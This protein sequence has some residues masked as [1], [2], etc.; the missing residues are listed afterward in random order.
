VTLLLATEPALDAEIGQVVGKY[1]LAQVIGKGGFGAVYRARHL[2]TGQQVALKILARTHDEIATKRFF[3]EA[4]VS[5]M[6][7]HPNTVRVFD[8]GQ[9][10]AGR[11]YLAMEL[12][13]GRSLR[14]AMRDRQHKE[15][16]FSEREAAEIGVAI[17]KSLAEAHRAGLV[18]RDIKPDNIFL[19]QIEDEDPVVKLL[20]FGI[21]KLTDGNESITSNSAIPGTPTFMSPEHAM[22]GHLD[23]RADLYSVGILLFLMVAGRVPFRAENAIQTLYM[24]V[25]IPVPDLN[26]VARTPLTPGFVAI[27]NKALQKDPAQRFSSAREMRLA[28]EQCLG[29]GWSQHSTS[30]GVVIP[31]LNLRY[32][33]VVDASGEA[34]APAGGF[35]PPITGRDALSEAIAPAGGFIPPI[36]GRDA[37]SEAIAPAGGFIPPITGRDPSAVPLSRQS[38]AQLGRPPGPEG[39]RPLPEGLGPPEVLEQNTTVLLPD[40]EPPPSSAPRR[41]WGR[42]RWLI[43]IG[44]LAAALSWAV[45]RRGEGPSAASPED[46]RAIVIAPA[47]RPSPSAAPTPAS[48]AMAPPPAPVALATSTAA[49]VPARPMA[50]RRGPRGHERRSSS[51]APR[52]P[53]VDEDVLNTRLR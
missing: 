15:E 36:T 43:A 14:Q 3:Q 41:S 45:V 21:A 20:D 2:A 10:E 4:Q 18:H 29:E 30:N 6:L 9:D 37:L 47:L 40:A 1:E 50:P 5:S 35:I 32:A 48:P 8:F 51:P 39:T 7:K 49:A 24:H 13:N 27:V 53:A 42:S 33:Q 31:S 22:N 34:I 28:L 46:R 11:L 17:L 38:T 23:G 16:V 12:L 25:H 44:A 52:R 26:Q 19:H